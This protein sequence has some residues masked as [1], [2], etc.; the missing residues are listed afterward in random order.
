MSHLE[1][2]SG[3]SSDNEVYSFMYEPVLV[4]DSTYSSTFVGDS[5]YDEVASPRLLKLNW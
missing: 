2:E 5:D 1:S 4:S 3:G